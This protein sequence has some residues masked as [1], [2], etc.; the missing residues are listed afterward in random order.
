MPVSQKT[1]DVSGLRITDAKAVLVI[2]GTLDG[3]TPEEFAAM[4]SA[5]EAVESFGTAFGTQKGLICK[6]VLMQG[7]VI[8][9]CYFFQSVEDVKTYLASDF[10]AGCEADTKWKD[11]VGE[12]FEIV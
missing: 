10:W 12:V 6:H 1:I 7:D 11:V 4:I 9:G 8:G 3:P 2:N 5:D